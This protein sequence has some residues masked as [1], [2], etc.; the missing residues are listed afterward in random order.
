M[1]V[2]LLKPSERRNLRTFEVKMRRDVMYNGILCFA[3][4]RVRA[5]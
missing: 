4:G 1:C 5:S 2:F 3:L